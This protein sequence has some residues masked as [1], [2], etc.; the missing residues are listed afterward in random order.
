VTVYF[1]DGASSLT[2][3]FEC[4]ELSPCEKDPGLCVAPNECSFAICD[5]DDPS[6]D[7]N[8]CVI[9]FELAGTACGSPFDTDCD[10]PDSC[11][12]LGT[13]QPNF[14]P[15]G[16]ICDDG[17]ACTDDFC[18]GIGG[19]DGASVNC[20]DGDP[21]T[22]DSCDPHFGCFNNPIQIP[23]DVNFDFVVDI[24]DIVAVVLDFGC[25][26]NPLQFGCSGDANGDERTDIDDIVFVVLNFGNTCE[27][28]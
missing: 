8:G 3:T 18:D 14:E 4:P 17:D 19:C 13:C 16:T 22:E 27:G 10:N 15:A 11:D 6:A 21:C 9:G 20:D 5:P 1:D 25:D 2:Q 12:G 26:V 7:A 28:T 23:G 24:D